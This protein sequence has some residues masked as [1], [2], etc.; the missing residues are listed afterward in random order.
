MKKNRKP[1]SIWYKMFYRIPLSVVDIA[2]HLKPWILDARNK[3]YYKEGHLKTRLHILFDYLYF[4]FCHGVS[5]KDD[6]YAMGI[7]QR[8]KKARDY[9]CEL[10][11][12]MALYAKNTSIGLPAM[13]WHFDRLAVL[14][15]KWIF[16]QMCQ[17]YGL[18]TPHIYGLIMNGSIISEEINDFEDFKLQERDLIIKPLDGYCGY[19]LFHL[20]C[21]NG[22]LI[23]KEQEISLAQL[24]ERV[25]KGLFLIQQFI[26]NQHKEMSRLYP[27]AVNTLRITV[28]REGDDTRVM[29]R[30]CMLGAHGTDC[31]NWHYGG[32]SVNLKEDGTLDKYGYCKIDKKVTAHPDTGVV[33]EGY[34]I[35]YFDEAIELARFATKC[36]YGICS[37]GWDVVITDDGPILLEGNDDW[38]IVAHQMVENRGWLK[39]WE[40][41]HGEMNF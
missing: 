31:S 10:E 1:W 21:V 8:G 17:A 16:S 7:D 12:T 9:I 36:F 33:F 5:V 37:I 25:K 40:Q 29:G 24:K 39:N 19:G 15:D 4:A 26:G 41:S 11:N 32:V 14:Q 34:K 2:V 22:K 23:V 35:P 13:K 38:G 27:D 3:T 30:M 28:A 6:Y 18:K 20:C